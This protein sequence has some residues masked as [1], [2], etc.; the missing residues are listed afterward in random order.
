VNRESRIGV[1]RWARR[2]VLHVGLHEDGPPPIADHR[3]LDVWKTATALTTDVYKATSKFPSDERF[4]LISQ[5]RRAA[6]SVP[7]NIAEGYGRE[8]SGSYIQFLRVAQGS[9]R[10]LETLLEVSRQLGYLDS[11]AHSALNDRLTRVTMMLGRLLRAIERR[12][13]Q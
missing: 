1:L 6:V 12:N 11:A 13:R 5:A 2:E 9:A 8:T 7:A 3:D 4:G 10:E